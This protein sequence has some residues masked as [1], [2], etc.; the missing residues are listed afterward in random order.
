MSLRRTFLGA[1][2]LAFVA[3]VS[4]CKISTINYFPPHPAT[5]RVLNL[6]TDGS[7]V[8]V[9]VGGNTMYSNVAAE[10]ATDYQSFDNQ[11][12]SFGVFLNGGSTSSISFSVPLAGEQP[13]TLVVFG[14]A[15]NPSAT[16]LSEV[17]NALTNGNIQVSVFNAAINISSVDIYVTAPGADITQLNPNYTFVSFNG[18]S[19]N[20]AFAP[21]TYQIQVTQQ[22]TKTVIFDSGGTVLQPNIALALILYSRGSA[23]LVN[24]AVLQSKGP[25]GFLTNIF[26]RLKGVNAG[27]PAVGP[28]NQLLGTLAV[29][30]NIAYGTT[31]NYYKGPAGNTTINF[32]A[33]ATPGAV[34]ASVPGTLVAANDY[35]AFVVGSAGAQQAYLLRDVNNPPTATGTVRLRFVNAMKGSN[36]VNVSVA[37]TT[38]ATAVAFPTASAYAQVT[39]A[40]AVPIT[41]TDTATGAT[42][43]AITP[44]LNVAQSGFT[45]IP[46]TLTL[47][48]I[49]SPSAPAVIITQD[50]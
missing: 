9:Q 12:T 17:A 48:L 36:P 18:S 3:L 37:G 10:S 35:S 13:Y 43:L 24:T 8:S 29:N 16:L 28:V 50:Q 41:F 42:I 30:T 33:S 5:V 14:T 38:Q 4:G 47:Y 32:E 23:T 27:D 19:L 25:T 2:A 15:A 1:V 22:G 44:D 39:S 45:T 49:G 34:I 6:M 46:L 21:G 26:A 31:S 20:L 7:T 11:T 40:A